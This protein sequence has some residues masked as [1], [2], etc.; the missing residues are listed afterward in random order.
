MEKMVYSHQT[1]S[2]NR[3]GEYIDS[4]S[5]TIGYIELI[6]K[7]GTND[8]I[9]VR[10]FL[11]LISA[12]RKEINLPKC[13]KKR[14]TIKLV[15]G[16]TIQ[17]GHAYDYNKKACGGEKYFKEAI[18]AYDEKRGIICVGDDSCFNTDVAFE[19]NK[20]V[21]CVTDQNLILKCIYIIPDTF[22]R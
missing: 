10:G 2:I 8:M 22:K 15:D 12:S 11:P 7:N 5:L 21:I 1:H 4:Y 3:L 17:G 14:F 9:D 6:F 16:A 20:N 13:D 18:I 19:I